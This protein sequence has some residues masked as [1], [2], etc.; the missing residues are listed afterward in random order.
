MAPR[1]RIIDAVPGYAREIGQLVAMMA[2][3]RQ[4]T[5]AAVKDL[6]QHELDYLHDPRS[7][8]VGG[9]LAHMAAV[10]AYYQAVS[11]EGRP[12]TADEDARFGAALA[13]GD[14]GR[15]ELRGRPVEHYL[16]ELDAVRSRT[17]VELAKRRDEWLRETVTLRDIMLNHHW[18]WFH[19]FED[20]LNHRGQIRWLSAR[21]KIAAP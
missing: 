13:L 4:T 12:L 2:Y 10:E 16:A 5:V 18:I 17:L 20:E 7:N 21:A 9:L 6:T 8:S 14:R 19:V 15:A 11:F 1:A 3:A